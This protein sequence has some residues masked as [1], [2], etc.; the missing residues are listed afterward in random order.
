MQCERK[1]EVKDDTKDLELRNRK[2]YFTIYQDG[3][4]HRR[5]FQREDQELS[6]GRTVIWMLVRP[7]CYA[8]QEFSSLFTKQ[9]LVKQL[10]CTRHYAYRREQ[11]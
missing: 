10:L 1:R 2:D 4:D 7:T 8:E 3:E 11:K 9:I 5:E 6:F